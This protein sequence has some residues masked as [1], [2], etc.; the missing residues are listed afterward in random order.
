[1]TESIY[2]AV[3][4]ADINSEHRVHVSRVLKILG[5]SKSGYYDWLK[6]PP[7]NRDQVKAKVKEAIQEIYDESRQIYG[8][9]KITKE[10]H[11]RGFGT[12]QSTVTR[13]M[14]EMGI[15]ACWVSPYVVTT[16][17]EDF[18]EELKNILS[19]DFSPEAPNTVW[20]TDI[21]YIYTSEGFVY[22][23]CIMDLYSRRI[24]AWEIAPTLETKYVIEAVR[25]AINRTG[26][27]P[28]V[29]HTD[30]GVQY[31]STSYWEATSSITKSY[32]RKGNPWDN[33]CIESFHSLLKREW[34]N[35]FRIK[36]IHQARCLVFDYI[37]AFYNTRRIHSFCKY[38]SPM[39]YER[40]YYEKQEN[41][42]AAA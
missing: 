3:K 28:K 21:T 5:V 39:K 32:S 8:A 30:R 20:C 18:S 14:K 6:R 34:L 16:L 25:K 22:L 36:D 38:L 7:S 41:R 1:M 9:P 24:V 26:M 23:S 35:R 13:Y 37:D 2:A 31:T 12:A 42:N 29:I 40:L 10:L 19:R 11:E 15:K 4:D 17:S 27:R 33:A